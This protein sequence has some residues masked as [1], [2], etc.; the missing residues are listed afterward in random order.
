MSLQAITCVLRIFIEQV[1]KYQYPTR[2]VQQKNRIIKSLIIGRKTPRFLFDHQPPGQ[3][4]HAAHP[5]RG[6][7]QLRRVLLPGTQPV[8]VGPEDHGGLG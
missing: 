3:P 8:R 7:E 2:L 4:P 5:E 6:R 1:A